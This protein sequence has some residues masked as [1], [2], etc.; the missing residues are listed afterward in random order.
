MMVKC[1]KCGTGWTSSGLPI[2]PICGTKVQEPAATP[3]V[4]APVPILAAA[5]SAPRKAANG[6]AV[7]ERA[8]ADVSAKS[9]NGDL[10][11]DDL[12]RGSVTLETH[13]GD[14]EIGIHDGTAAWL[15]VSATAGRVHN[16]LDAADAPG[17]TGDKAEVRARTSLGD[18]VVRR[19][20]AVTS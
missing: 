15:D 17:A 13:A 19:A 5:D 18:I 7:I 3:K 1:H 9:A 10:R 11:V 4:A 12:V 14:I 2:C 16:H 8:E 6:S 20:Q